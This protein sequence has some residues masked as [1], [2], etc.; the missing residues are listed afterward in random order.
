MKYLVPCFIVVDVAKNAEHAEE[1]ARR[2]VSMKNGS[3][4]VF[5]EKLPTIEF[6][7]EWPRTMEN[8]F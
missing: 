8:L 5:D 4:L 3:V 7:G 6:D 2:H 1:L